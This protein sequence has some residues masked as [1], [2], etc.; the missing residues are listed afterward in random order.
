MS[1]L[2]SLF[3]KDEYFLQNYI[4]LF[5]SP[6]ILGTFTPKHLQAWQEHPTFV[7]RIIKP[8]QHENA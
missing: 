2:V 3:I 8:T 4:I 7:V 5:D 1:S 6:T